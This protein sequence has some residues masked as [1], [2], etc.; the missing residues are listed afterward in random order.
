[1]VLVRSGLAGVR[2]QGL[3]LA[4]AAIFQLIYK[5]HCR[6]ARPVFAFWLVACRVFPAG[7]AGILLFYF[8]LTPGP[9]G[10]R[11]REYFSLGGDPA[12][13][14]PTATLLRLNPPYRT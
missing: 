6:Q 8:T 3:R 9:Y 7:N 12:A 10:A 2:T 14:S 5:P 4:K 13:D 1:M 11:R